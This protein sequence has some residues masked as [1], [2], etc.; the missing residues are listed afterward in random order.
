MVYANHLIKSVSITK[1]AKSY[2][3]NGK[4]NGKEPFISLKKEKIQ[5]N[6]F[7]NPVKT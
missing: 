2:G 6:F 5:P 4:N 3:L 1:K 7:Q